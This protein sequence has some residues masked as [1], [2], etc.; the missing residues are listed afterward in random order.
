M[1]TAFSGIR[2]LAQESYGAVE[3]SVLDAAV[4]SDELR[5]GGAM[6]SD[7]VALDVACDIDV[8]SVLHVFVPWTVKDQ[9]KRVQDT[10]KHADI[11]T[12]L[13][14][15]KNNEA[16]LIRNKVILTG[17][18]QLI[19]FTDSRE[20]GGTAYTIK[21]ALAVNIPV[22]IVLVKGTKNPALYIPSA[23]PQ[24]VYHAMFPYRSE[25]QKHERVDDALL[26]SRIIR[27]LKVGVIVQD[28]LNWLAD[29]VVAYLQRHPIL[30]K[31][32][33]TPM[34]RRAPAIA[35][36]LLPLAYEISKRTGQTV[37][38]NWLVRTVEPTDGKVLALR[39]RYSIEE[40]A[41]TMKVLGSPSDVLI[42]DNV[43]TSGGTSIGAQQAILRDTGV[44]APML[45]ILWSSDLGVSP[46]GVKQN[47]S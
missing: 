43:I 31:P 12:E 40:H 27:H 45:S 38:E 47:G 18:D 36:D 28:E 26:A 20:E 8:R 42:L 44:V 46:F 19:A 3:M 33:I 17:A 39:T 21:H 11:V 37:L 29:R 4:T 13:G 24:T 16:Y 9:P 41:R 6:G 10:I 32:C 14:L 35:S 2:D 15:P 30:M 23:M 25:R 7:T 1:I 22:E 5:F 34:P